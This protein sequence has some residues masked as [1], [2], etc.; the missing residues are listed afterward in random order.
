MT[1]IKN[2][3]SNKRLIA[4]AN[5]FLLVLGVTLYLVHLASANYDATQRYEL[6]QF[7]GQEQAL[8]FEKQSLSVRV[9]ELQS[10]ERLA[11]ESERLQLV[12]A[13]TAR[14]VTVPG[15]VALKP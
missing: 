12:K 13:P 11:A 7:R 10:L 15:A 3:K 8:L 6:S 14:F 9:A 5:G 1:Q 2:K 4:Q